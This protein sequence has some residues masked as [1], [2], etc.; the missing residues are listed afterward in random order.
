[1]IAMILAHIY[2]GT[3]G[4]EGAFDTMA[5]SQVDENWAKEHHSLWV[6]SRDPAEPGDD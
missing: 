6:E 1:M 4:L 3:I 2:I 5:T